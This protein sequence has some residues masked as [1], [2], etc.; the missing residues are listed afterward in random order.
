[1]N[2]H[3]PA[4]DFAMSFTQE[5]VVLE[6]R[7][8]RLWRPLG[9][10]RFAGPDL[11]ATLNEMRGRAGGVPGRLDTVLVI[12]DD[13]ILYTT[14]TVPVGSDTPAALARAL[15]SMTPYPAADLAFDWCPS[16][17]GDIETLRVAA[18]AR[19]TLQE[20]ED[21]A[22]AQGF[23]PSGFLARPGDARFEGDPDFGPSRL[24][25]E[26]AERPPFSEPDLTQ[27]RI[28]A[29]EV[30]D[31]MP[32]VSA[33]AAPSAAI[34]SRITPHHVAPAKDPGGA[35]RMGAAATAP[36][37]PP[38]Q[39]G[40]TDALASLESPSSPSAPAVIRHGQRHADPASRRLSPRAEAVHQRAAEARARRP[41][42]QDQASRSGSGL[43]ARLTGIKVGRLPAMI[44][45]LLAALVV[46]LWLF[47]GG[48]EPD[49]IAGTGQPE[50]APAA[51]PAADPAAAPAAVGL[52]DPA[53]AATEA[54]PADAG[55]VETA[56]ASDPAT[57][58]EDEDPAQTAD[59]LA[60][61]Q[62]PP[63]HA[64]ATAPTDQPAD[65]PLTRALNE[66]IQGGPDGAAPETSQAETPVPD[67]PRVE[68]AADPAP[69][70]PDPAATASTAPSPD[71]A[72][73][74]AAAANTLRLR[75]SARPPSSPPARAAAPAEPDTRPAVPS[76]PLPFARRTEAEPVRLTGVRPP[77]RPARGR[78][79]AAPQP[80]PQPAP[81]QQA[82]APAAPAAETPAAAPRPAPV[83]PRAR[84]D[85]LTLLEEG[86]RSEDRADAP[87]TDSERAFLLGLLHDL[88]TA[89][90]G[91]SG[92]SDAERD[93][94]IRLADARP[95]RKPVAV[96]RP[97]GDAVRAAVAQAVAASDRPEPRAD[98]AAPLPA[99]ASIA[100]L[101][102]SARPSAR[103]GGLAASSGGDPGPGRASLSGKAVEDAIAAAVASSTALPGAVAL[104]ALSSSAL[105]PRRRGGSSANAAPTAP[106]ADDLRAAAA[107]QQ[108]QAA[109]EEQR[110]MDAALQAQAEARAR[111]RAAADAQAE[112]NARAQAEARA[113][114]QAEA[115]ARAA[116]ARKQNYTP[117]EA[118]KE[119]EVAANV[120]VARGQ[121]S[122]AANATIKDGITLSR[123]QIIGTIGAGK[124]SRALVRLSNGRVITLR[125]GDK[126]NGGTITDIGNSR[127][128]YVKGGRPQ[129]L[130]VLNGQ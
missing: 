42:P 66:A 93:V 99:A 33:P 20:A 120:A 36:A 117:P 76:D 10:A 80:A 60:A 106:T 50:P 112:A 27:A 44:M 82:P 17:T 111:A 48:S 96:A 78:P 49:R 97:S 5:A 67:A 51:D 107:A 40:D 103:P 26:Q 34:V 128:T 56:P 104:T 11:A 8:G 28:T 39:V 59:D 77:E 124:A 108:E 122:A 2:Q 7:D 13:Q 37:T 85:G 79:A 90:L 15:E 89:Q 116:A 110:R 109:I 105:P 81:I 57:A 19:R 92:P 83:R 18:V 12:P 6:R 126:I 125:L 9:Q 100:G 45:G 84:P 98:A 3:A 102:R 94:L 121:G 69:A 23:R 115:E 101:S 74:A 22:R 68:A 61:L 47:G 88:R 58:A 63:E 1:M 52:A 54:T 30:E 38:A 91:S 70:R 43:T 14:V 55:P 35:D 113:R 123:T 21:F 127:I 31:V 87:L 75:S 129:Q 71:A 32:E 119:P 29:P 64:G 65:D 53:P 73:R 46:V 16:E 4:P 95:Q 24:S 72:A 62:A 130:S 86:S 114:A 25:S 41:E 118:E